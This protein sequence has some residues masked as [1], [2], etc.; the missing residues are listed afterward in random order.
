MF[1]TQNKVKLFFSNKDIACFL[2]SP[3]TQSFFGFKTGKSGEFLIIS[4]A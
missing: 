4:M 2:Y 1:K 3:D